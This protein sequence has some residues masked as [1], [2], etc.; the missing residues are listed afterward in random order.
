VK[1]TNNTKETGN[2][3]NYLYVE[4]I[5]KIKRIVIKIGSSS[6]THATGKLNLKRI[7]SLVKT[8]SDLSNAGKEIILV[9]SGAIP[10]GAGKLGMKIPL[11]KVE[12]KKAA[13]AVG[14]AEL[15]NIYERF[16]SSFGIKIAQILLTRDVIE[17]EVRRKNAEETF[18]V[19]LRMGCVPI[20]NENDTVSS[21]EI[22]F[23]GND[24][25]SAYVSKL[26]KA[27]LVINLTDRDGLYDKNPTDFKDAK[28]IRH[29]P[30]ITP[31]VLSYGG[32]AG[33][34]RGTGGFATKLQAAQMLA[35]DNTPMVL[36]NAKN[37]EIL[38]DILDGKIAGTYIGR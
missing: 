22:K 32:G 34:S 14:Q 10:A 8:I 23:S 5:K 7:E 17:N 6:L 24:I 13:A 12:D 1:N 35:E 29:V 21:D 16:F 2:S 31:E 15:M 19:L 3:L 26:C 33:S 38:Y 36:A 25:L 18:A 11:T 27:D 20:V 4:S 30:E 37:L 9:T 28:L